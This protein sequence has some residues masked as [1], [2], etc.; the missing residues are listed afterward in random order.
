MPGFR[1][2][3]AQL[4]MIAEVAKAL[5]EPAGAAVIEAPTGTGKSMA[6]LIAGLEVARATKKKLLIATA[7][8]ALQGDWS[9]A[10]FPNS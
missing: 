6:Y 5:A 1:G 2:R 9:S 4:K 10:I 7:T 3:P 8:V